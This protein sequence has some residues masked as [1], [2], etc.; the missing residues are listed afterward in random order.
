MTKLYKNQ[1]FENERDLYGA[2]DVIIENCL[3]D[4]PS[5]GE[6]FL[7]EAKNVQVNNSRFHLRYPF[8]HVNN[9]TISNSEMNETCRALIW[10]SQNINISNS[11]LNG[12]KALRECA[13][14][15]LSNLSINS[16]EFCWKSHHIFAK[17]IL[18]TSEYAFLE[19]SDINLNNLIF[20][21]KYSF[22]YCKDV[23][24]TNS[25]F[26]TKDCFWHASNVTIKDSI[27][28]GEYLGWYSEN[29]T[30]INCKI[31]GTQPL[32]YA[33]NLKLIDCSMEGCDLAFEYSEV[34][35]DIVSSMKSIKNPKSGNIIVQQVDEIIISED[36]V[37]PCGAKIVENG[38]IK[39]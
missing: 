1:T 4:G 27:I 36:S 38:K 14:V 3:V 18:L 7:K 6:S 13:Y 35:A 16:P 31:S 32:C 25:K 8:W 12:I 39:L 23:L 17:N 5:D 29:L 28:E 10:Y 11:K 19:S 9:L 34:E 22:Q 30:F 24:I 20:E 33:K 26:N 2:Q 37:Y 21:G 15:N